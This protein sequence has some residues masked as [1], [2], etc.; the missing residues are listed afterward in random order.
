MYYMIESEKTLDITRDLDEARSLGKLDDNCHVYGPF[1][2]MNDASL[3]TAHINKRP[4][5]IVVFF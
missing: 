5:P 2:S 1:K 4:R 3:A